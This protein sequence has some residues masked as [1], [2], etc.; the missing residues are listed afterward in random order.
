MIVL[1]VR[2]KDGSRLAGEYV[3]AQE[4]Y[5]YL[6]TA[7]DEIVRLKQTDAEHYEEAP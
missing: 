1:S 4:G 5:L 6:R 7:Q 2:L 3:G